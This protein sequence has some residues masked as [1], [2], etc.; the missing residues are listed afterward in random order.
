M[1]CHDVNRTVVGPPF[2]AVARKY[3]GD[4]QAAVRLATRSATAAAAPGGSVPM[5]AQAQVQEADAEALA[6]WILGG[7]R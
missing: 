5:P 2:A 6:R 1:T 3:A 7:A 4:S